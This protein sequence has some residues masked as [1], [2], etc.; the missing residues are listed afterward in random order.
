MT[1]DR[2]KDLIE[3]DN[4]L[5][6]SYW[7]LQKRVKRITTDPRFADQCGAWFDRSGAHGAW[8]VYDAGRVIL[9]RLQEIETEGLSIDAALE[10]LHD[11]LDVATSPTED[12]AVEQVSSPDES[13]LPSA[14][15]AVME[16]ELAVLRDER[17]DLRIQRDRLL[18]VIES[19]TLALPRPDAQFVDPPSKRRLLDRFLRRD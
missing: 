11:E 4:Q 2:L 3:R 1:A 5:R 13:G 19:M 18:G 9:L 15:V 12:N 14:N 16:A 17:D 8:Q 7:E 10:R 6:M